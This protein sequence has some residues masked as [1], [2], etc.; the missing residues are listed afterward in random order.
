MSIHNSVQSSN[1]RSRISKRSMTIELSSLPPLQLPTP[2]TNT[3]IITNINDPVIFQVA[4]L[5]HIK[6][7][8]N[9][10]A[11]IHSW[12][13]LK[14]FHRIVVSFFSIDAAVNI[15]QLLDGEEIMGTRAKIYFGQS[16]PIQPKDEYLNLP[17]AGKLFFISPP[18]SPPHGWQVKME[19]APNKQVMAN[20]LAQA[21]AKLHTQSNQT[22]FPESPV[23]DCGDF[24]NRTRSGST[25]ML[26]RPEEHGCSPH[27]P[28]INVE[29]TTC[30]G[31]ISPID[32]VRPIFAH[33]S[34]PPPKIDI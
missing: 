27:L 25:T 33:T 29:D 11:P 20:D 31:E 2:P 32:C 30:D 3:L 26:Y 4:N 23:S 6:D 28:A 17:D 34:L 14:S 5:E 10:V 19:D 7:T 1:P 24:G 9:K 16:T 22:R 12:A 15:R 21:L 18:P 13:P 8:I